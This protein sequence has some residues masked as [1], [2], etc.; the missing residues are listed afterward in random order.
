VYPYLVQKPFTITPPA[1]AVARHVVL[2]HRPLMPMG[3]LCSDRPT[4]ALATGF[5]C[6]TAHTVAPPAQRRSHSLLH[7]Q[8]CRS[9]VCVTPAS[10][11]L[12]EHARVCSCAEPRTLPARHAPSLA[13]AHALAP[14]HLHA[15][16]A[17]SALLLSCTPEPSPFHSPPCAI[18]GHLLLPSSRTCLRAPACTRCVPAPAPRSPASTLLRAEPSACRSNL[19]ALQSSACLLPVRLPHSGPRARLPRAEPPPPAR[20]CPLLAPTPS[21]PLA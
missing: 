5:R 7:C 6:V 12:V 2:Q 1:R 8:P 18:S 19:H 4:S 14:V 3:P 20:A 10:R 13:R 15:S 21:R 16:R 9:R 11:Q 17:R